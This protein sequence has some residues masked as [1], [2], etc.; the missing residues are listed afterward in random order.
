[1]AIGSDI[2]IDTHTDTGIVQTEFSHDFDHY[3]KLSHDFESRK[4]YQKS[5]IK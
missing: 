4:K 5:I 3:L 1:M 2:M